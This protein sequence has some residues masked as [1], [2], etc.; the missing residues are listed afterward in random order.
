[1]VG[2]AITLPSVDPADV[3]APLPT[4]GKGFGAAN[5][6]CVGARNVNSVLR[7]R[8]DPFFL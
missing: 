6:R 8:C 3:V 7:A 4:L 1:M 5:R 2:N